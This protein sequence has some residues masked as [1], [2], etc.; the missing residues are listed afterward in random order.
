MQGRVKS[1][2]N[3]PIET[4]LS[5]VTFVTST[6]GIG[7]RENLFDVFGGLARSILGRNG[8]F[9][10]SR[11]Y[12][13]NNSKVDLVDCSWG[14]LMTLANNVP[15]LNI[16]ISEGAK[17]FSGMEIKHYQGI[18]KDRK[19]VQNSEV[20]KFLQKP[21]PLQSQ[22]DFLYEFYVQNA[23]YRTTFCYVNTP[24]RLSSI[25]SALWWLP[26]ES[27]KINLTG[28][29]FDQVNI[30]GIIESYEL[31]DYDKKYD[32]KDVI[33]IIDGISQNK[34]TA[35]PTIES[36]QVTLSNIMAVLK[37]YNIIVSERGMI[38]FIASERSDSTGLSIPMTPKERTEFQ[39]QYQKDYSLDAKNGHVMMTE[40][41]M[42]WVPMTFD[43][44]QLMLFEGLEDS[45]AQ[46]CA[47][48][49]HKRDIYPSTKGATFENQKQAD[50]GTYQTTMQPLG[51]KVLNQ[52]A[53]RFQLKDKGQYLE[54]SWEHMPMMQENEEEKATALNT[55][56]QAYSKMLSD[57][58][59]SAEQYAELAGVKMDGT[60]EPVAVTMNTENNKMKSES[61]KFDKKPKKKTNGGS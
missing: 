9:N 46:I 55:N 3:Q 19:E 12:K 57:G 4:K 27:M 32:P 53:Q 18:G 37:S 44:K 8:K 5:F 15:H 33:H 20:L 22:S 39:N 60:G 30:D 48:Y 47:A 26:G 10:F 38:G 36:L 50:V 21:N 6:Y 11:D 59:I 40:S 35:K 52:L 1:L 28:K 14:N 43:V 13:P 24:S 29:M 17:M 51:Q 45:F 56:V 23:I 34:I 2:C 41:S 31:M 16:V 25:P 58:I 7:N 61:T 42:K 54:P 49:G